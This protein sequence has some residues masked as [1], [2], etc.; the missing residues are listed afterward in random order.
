MTS[1]QFNFR[2]RPHLL[3]PIGSLSPRDAVQN[4]IEDGTLVDLDSIL[5]L[6]QEDEPSRHPLQ[7]FSR[8]HLQALSREEW[9]GDRRDTNESQG[10]FRIVQS[11]RRAFGSARFAL[12]ALLWVGLLPRV[13]KPM[14]LDS[15]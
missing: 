6:K 7:A 3:H 10:V 15:P 8:Y 9:T 11:A 1:G 14:C 2:A 4:V 5:R 13:T 12:A